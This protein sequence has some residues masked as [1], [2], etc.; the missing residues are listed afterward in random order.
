MWNIWKRHL[1]CTLFCCLDGKT[2]PSP[3]WGPSQRNMYKMGSQAPGDR[4][5]GR[6]E[7]GHLRVQEREL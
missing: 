4:V 3:R 5:M 6:E 2:G 7:V 1:C